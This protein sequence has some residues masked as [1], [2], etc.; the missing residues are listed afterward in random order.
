MNLHSP[1]INTFGGA[2]IAEHDYACPVCHSNKA[3][4]ALNTGVFN[5]CDLC[6]SRGW[7][8]RK[9]K[10]LKGRFTWSHR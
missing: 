6:R 1:Q 4:L 3:V 5:P 9:R 2:P 10:H 8:L 7:E